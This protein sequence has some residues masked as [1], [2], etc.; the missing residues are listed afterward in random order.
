MSGPMASG[1]GGGADYSSQGFPRGQGG[2]QQG[3]QFRGGS[4]F[5]G[6]RDG[7]G[8]GR[9]DGLCRGGRGDGGRGRG[10]GGGGGADAG[11]SYY[12]QQ[13]TATSM[14]QVNSSIQGLPSAVGARKKTRFG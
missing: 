1:F 9:G 5:G 13:A 4:S 6:G 11:G 8:R 3:G 7:G 14:P 2:G 10:G 12:Q